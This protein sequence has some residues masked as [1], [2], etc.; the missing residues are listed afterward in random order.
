MIVCYHLDPATQDIRGVWW[1][2]DDGDQ[3]SYEYVD[4]ISME[5]LEGLEVMLRKHDQVSWPAYW[6]RLD[7]RSPYGIWWCVREVDDES[8][9]DELIYHPTTCNPSP[10][11][12]KMYE[13]F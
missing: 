3:I 4:E 8:Y 7:E 13:I 6:K 12:W 10:V 2:V 11:D 9:G 1:Q 5:M